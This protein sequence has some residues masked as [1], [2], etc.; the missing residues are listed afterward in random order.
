MKP[1][2]EEAHIFLFQILISFWDQGTPL[3][4]W[5]AAQL[6]LPQEDFEKAYGVRHVGVRQLMEKYAAW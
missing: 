6:A 5:V 4:D 1:S 3:G 2:F